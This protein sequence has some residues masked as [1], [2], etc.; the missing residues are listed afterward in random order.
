MKFSID[1]AQFFSNVDLVSLPRDEVVQRLG[2]QLGAIEEVIDWAPRYYGLIIVEVVK[3][4]KHPNADK[5]SIC[6]VN[7]GRVVEDV[8]RDKDGLV[9]IVC[10]ASNV[11][12]GMLAAWIPPGITVPST[13]SDKRPVVME[14]RE[15]RGK[16]SNGMLASPKELDI[17]EEHQGILDISADELAHRPTPGEALRDFFGLDDFIIDCENKMFTHRPDCFGNLGIARELAGIFGL[18]FKSPD[19]YLKP[20]VQEKD[21]KDGFVELKVVNNI[22]ELVPRF[23]I[24]T[25]GNIK[26]GPSPIW[27]QSTLKR[28]GIKPIS[29]IVDI[30][31]YVMH[32]TGQPLHAFDYDKLQKC[33]NEPSLSPRLAKEG[34]KITLLGGREVTL[35]K[36]D[37]VIATDKQAV[38][39]AGIMGGADTE[40][41]INTRNIVIECANFDMYAIRRT[42]MRHGIFT[43][44][45]TRFNKGQSP[46]QNDRVLAYVMKL[47]SEQTGAVLVSPVYD[48]AGFDLSADNLDHLRVEVDFINAKL[49][50]ELTPQQIKVL[51]ENVEFIVDIQGRTLNITVPFW[52]MDVAIADDIV[53]EVGRLYG[54]SKLPVRLPLRSSKPTTINKTRR[55]K[56]QLRD[57]LVGAGA[58]ELLTYSFVHGNLLDKIGVDANASAYH[59]RNALSPDLQYYRTNLTA[60]ILAKVHANIKQ[61]AGRIDNE[62]ALFELGKTHL[63]GLKEPDD[64]GLPM[65]RRRLAFVFT[66]DNKIAK[67]YQSSAYYQVKKYLDLITNNQT[68]Y[69][70][71]E[72]SD[73]SENTFYQKG[74][75]AV[76][77]IGEVEVGT[78]GEYN[79][80]VK[81]DLKLPDFTAGFELDTDLLMQ[82]L[83]KKTYQPISKFPDS[84]QDMTLEVDLSLQWS[85]VCNLLHAELLVYGAEEGY[86]F[87]IEPLDIFRAEG[88]DKKRFTYRVHIS[89]HRKTLKTEEV[90]RII[91]HLAKVTNEKFKATLI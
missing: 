27:L 48:L 61:G 66:A 82:H 49:D 11:T 55:F 88:S 69:T 16:V 51:L 76:V 54:Y 23:T 60:S 87:D 17:S 74:R 89:N 64:S 79:N 40:V 44:A 80:A 62:F 36:D 5:L 37:I 29:K 84:Q 42:S 28:V 56:Q 10:G 3:C 53:E 71:L 90:S 63:K 43:D 21:K 6:L 91:K 39:I 24:V 65:Q 75:G 26:N 1:M 67:K 45:V 22:S 73:N 7:D 77:S 58:N 18:Q 85:D 70:P 4:E 46:L 8:E 12:A 25:M 34:E 31:N 47:M 13:F 38:A 81:K 83:S 15:L 32:L 33:S 41:D 14:S 2:S 52:R 86:T 19:W 68:I 50:T 20:L 30:T 59:L 78:I 57:I 72:D 9:Q 35:T